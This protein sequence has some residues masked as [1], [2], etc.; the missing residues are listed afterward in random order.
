[1]IQAHVEH[2]W[3][4]EELVSATTDQWIRVLYLIHRTFLPGIAGEEHKLKNA[5]RVKYQSIA[6]LQEPLNTGFRHAR[7]IAGQGN[8]GT[9]SLAVDGDIRLQQGNRQTPLQGQ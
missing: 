1:M 3:R 5:D 4:S 2:D 9:K 7:L 6:L 8:V